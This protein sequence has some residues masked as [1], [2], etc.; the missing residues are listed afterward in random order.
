MPVVL[1]IEDNVQ[2]SRLYTKTLDHAGYEVSYSGTCES[3]IEFLSQTT[4]DV[5]ILDMLLPDGNGFS[6]LEW[7]RSGPDRARFVC[8]KVVT[9][10]GNQ[11]F[12]AALK[13]AGVNHALFKPVSTFMLVDVVQQLAPAGV[14]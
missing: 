12:N 10:T 2:L 5:I 13:R 8:T 7:M 11:S 14:Q 4:P 9:V 3:A 6:I 1:I